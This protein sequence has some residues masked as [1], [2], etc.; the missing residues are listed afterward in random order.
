LPGVT[1][2]TTITIGAPVSTA[3]P[4][5]MKTGN[6]PK[7]GK[8]KPEYYPAYASYF[9]KY[10]Q[11]M[12]AEGIRIDAITVQN[13]VVFW[14]VPSGLIYSVPTAGGSVTTVAT[15]S[16][17]IAS[18]RVTN[19]T[20]V[21]SQTTYPAVVFAQPIGGSRI[22]LSS[23]VN[24]EPGL[25]IQDGFAY[26]TGSESIYR[27]PIGGGTRQTLASNLNDAYYLALDATNIYWTLYASGSVMKLRVK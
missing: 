14:G 18:I 4:S 2:A 9:V 24:V 16:Q 11:G 21:W 15:G 1:N 20:V 13:N 22:T 6:N 27:V 25:A 7:G 10:I 19:N 23:G 5:W 12:K 8:L 26:F 3:A 17:D